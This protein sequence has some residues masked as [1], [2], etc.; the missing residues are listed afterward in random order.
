MRRSFT[1]SDSW[2]VAAPVDDVAATLVDL[3][4]YPQWWPQVRAVA[5]L[6]P[7]T[8]WVR[9]RSALPYTLDLVLDAVSRT[10]PVVEVAI[11]GDLDG[12][13]RF[14][15]T[16]EARG[17]RLDFAQEVTVGGLLAL[18]SYGGRWLLVWNHRRM[19]AGCRDG[20][21]TRV[22]ELT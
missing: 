5:K 18:A 14:T 4:H 20:L 2:L 1:F 7:D 12:F 13:A 6:G 8:A 17:T 15:L 10:P 11:G 9:C 16:A 22:A 3:E 21:A 19:M